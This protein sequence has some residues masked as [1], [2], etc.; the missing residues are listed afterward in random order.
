[1]AEEGGLIRMVS[2]AKASALDKS[3]KENNNEFNP[4]HPVS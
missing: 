4:D 2:A 1:M 3:F